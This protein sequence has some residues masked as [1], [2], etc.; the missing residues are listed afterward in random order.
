MIK[1]CI[2]VIRMHA[3]GDFGEFVFHGLLDVALIINDGDLQTESSQAQ[4]SK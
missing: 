1:I 2:P 3:S 4:V